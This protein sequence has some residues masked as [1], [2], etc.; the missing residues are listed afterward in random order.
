M[1]DAPYPPVAK[2]TTVKTTE[3]DLSLRHQWTDEGWEA[4]QWGVRGTVIMYHDSHGLCY[5][6]LHEDGTEGCYDPSEIEVV[7]LG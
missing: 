1:A 4:R 2:G 7:V 6:V 3:P 5:D